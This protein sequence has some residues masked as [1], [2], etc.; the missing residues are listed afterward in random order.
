MSLGNVKNI[1][2][3]GGFTGNTTEGEI[4]E[5]N[6]YELN[7]TTLN[8]NSASPDIIYTPPAKS[9][10]LNGGDEHESNNTRETA[11]RMSPLNHYEYEGYHSHVIADLEKIHGYDEWDFYTF[12][13][14]TD[15]HV[16]INAEL[17]YSTFAFDFGITTYTS[18]DTTNPGI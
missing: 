7:N 2:E 3:I 8:S 4:L 13:L 9:N 6:F 15:S 16:S 11:T 10:I 18:T 12:V 1:N 14:L 5:N 17:M